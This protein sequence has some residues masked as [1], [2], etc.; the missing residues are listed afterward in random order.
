MDID[1]NGEA[2]GL[3]EDT[4]KNRFA[5]SHENKVIGFAD[6]IDRTDD[7]QT[8]RTFT[9]TEVSPEFGGR[10]LA[11]KLVNFALETTAE[12]DVKFRTTCSYVARFLDKHHEFDDHLV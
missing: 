3:S 1:V 11:A 2:Y 12:A 7:G 5:L 9:H 4:A 6:Y 8:V 10:G